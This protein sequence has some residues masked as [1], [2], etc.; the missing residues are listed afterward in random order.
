VPCITTAL[1]GFGL[2]AN[3]EKGAYCEIEDDVK[4]VLRTDYNYSEVA[5]AIK[6]AV[7]NLFNFNDKQI[8]V[9]RTIAYNLSKKALWIEFIKYYYQ[10]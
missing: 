2:R 10:S 3:S 7:P 4:V 6:D 9:A 5:G 8:K 1:A